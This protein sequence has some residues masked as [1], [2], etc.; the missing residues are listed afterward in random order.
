MTTLWMAWGFGQKR[1]VQSLFI[2]QVQ[3]PVSNIFL[4]VQLRVPV[5]IFFVSAALLNARIILHLL[6]I[7]GFPKIN[8]TILETFSSFL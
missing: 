5:L 3:L 1:N 6:L 7:S 8:I 2:V 4:R